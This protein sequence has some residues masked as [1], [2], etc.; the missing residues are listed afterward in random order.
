MIPIASRI[1]QVGGPSLA[2]FR[3]L[4]SSRGWDTTHTPVDDTR[5]ALGQ[6]RDQIGDLPVGLIGHSLGGRAALLAGSEPAVRSVVALA[7]WVYPDESPDL[8]GRRVLIVHGSGDRIAAPAKSRAVARNIAATTHVGYITIS[9]GRHAML[10]HHRQ[11]DGY[12]AAFTAAVLL[13][14]ERRRIPGPVRQALDGA[15]WVTA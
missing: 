12:A 4:N 10:R 3:L 9:G 8:S 2:V 7:P 13:P 1:A 15:E 5:W 14:D 6:L 11:F